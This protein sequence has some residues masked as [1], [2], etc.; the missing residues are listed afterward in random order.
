MISDRAKSETIVSLEAEIADLK[1]AI[2]SLEAEKVRM[3]E[4]FERDIE[5]LNREWE[6]KTG[7]LKDEVEMLQRQVEQGKKEMERLLSVHAEER[8]QW[9]QKN[10]DLKEEIEEWKAIISEMKRAHQRQLEEAEQKY[11]Q[12]ITQVEEITGQKVVVEDHLSI[13]QTASQKLKAEVDSLKAQIAAM[14]GLQAECDRRGE[15][16]QALE[17]DLLRA[18][19]RIAELEAEIA[20]LSDDA[21]ARYEALRREI[22]RI[23]GFKIQIEGDLNEEK[24]TTSS[25]KDEINRLLRTIEELKRIAEAHGKSAARIHELELE[26]ARFQKEI[27]KLEAKKGVFTEEWNEAVLSPEHHATADHPTLHSPRSRSRS[28]M[29]P[30]FSL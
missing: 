8:A 9:E 17:Q 1:T 4:A 23:T 29:S 26:V 13:E 6:L 3:Q 22:E 16:I 11:A 21:Q 28:P 27:R 2:E 30:T 24:T 15:R 19:R 18:N 10:T 25:L 12:L 20:N 7:A 5:A 14:A